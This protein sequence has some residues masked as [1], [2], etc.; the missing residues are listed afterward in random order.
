MRTTIAAAV[1]ATLMIGACSSISKRQTLPSQL[2]PPSGAIDDGNSQDPVA[3]DHR[4]EKAFRE[5]P[6][7]AMR[8]L[9]RYRQGKLWS[10]LDAAKACALWLEV[11]SSNG[12]PLQLPAKIHALENC[13]V[14]RAETNQFESEI[15]TAIAEPKSGWLKPSAVRA[16]YARAKKLGDKA[17][18]LKWSLE[19]APYEKAQSSQLKILDSALSLAKDSKDA[20]MEERAR[21]LIE[22]TAPRRIP[23]PKKE[24]WL[25]VAGDFRR[26]RDFDQARAMYKKILDDSAFNDFEKLKALD[27]VRS[28]FKLENQREKYVSATREFAEFAR[29]KFLKAPK[30]SS[31]LGKYLESRITLA[32]AVWT[33]NSPREAATILKQAEKDLKGRY[34]VD[35]SVFL[36]ARI[37]EEAGRY[38][39][40]IRLL[41]R[42][43]ERRINDRPMRLKIQWSR[44]WMLRKSKRFSEAATSLEKLV[45]DEDSSASISKDHFWL[46]RTYKDL[47]QTEK[48][49]A[50]FQWL[51]ENDPIGY[52]GTLA[53]RETNRKLPKLKENIPNRAPALKASREPAGSPPGDDPLGPEERITFEW[54][55]ATSELELA[56]GFLE[57]A[58]PSRR[59]AMNE[60]QTLTLLE[61]FARAGAYQALFSRLPD[62]PSDVRRNV[63]EQKPELIFPRPWSNAVNQSA[64]K[65][66]ISPEIVYSI[67]RQESSFDPHARS[68]ADAF[69][70]MQLIPEMAQR[71][72]STSSTALTNPE[73]LYKPELNI[74]LG[75]TFLRETFNKWNGRFIP[76]VASYNASDRAVS[77]WLK[78]RDR[79]DPLAFIEDIP[80]DETRA[81]VKL[82]MRNFIF[83]SRLSTTEEGIAFP[84][85]CLAGL[86][87][88]NP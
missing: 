70:L 57:A 61:H 17:R 4:L 71:A 50:E 54:L 51:I 43:D 83:Y 67:I 13:P 26:A 45:K 6:T 56:K 41:D 66:G 75:A 19:I 3:L 72:A 59:S 78:T 32:R 18:E 30:N 81:Y 20:Q 36:R 37:E 46:G 8:L 62:I 82:V 22:R 49:N 47:G 52:Y 39:E 21:V 11:A 64:V 55:I 53:F 33:E 42:I 40:A 79:H 60:A 10:T 38:A 87:D 63:L 29:E 86:Q 24:Q 73:D 2:W 7:E 9:V 31:S 85:W 77:N 68:S 15:A 16:S 65:A 27:G 58:G 76:A 25:A 35:D 1:T 48:A 5:N 80:Y 69:G 44:A 28:T 34:P 84:E 74:Q 23:E 12:F 14:D 88:P